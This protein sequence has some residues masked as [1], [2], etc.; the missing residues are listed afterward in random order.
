MQDKQ[1]ERLQTKIADTSEPREIQE[2]LL[3]TGWVRRKLACGDYMFFN[4]EFKRVGIERKSVDD[5][6]TLSLGQRL[7][8]Q[9]EEMLDY[10]DEVILLIE[11]SWKTVSEED[12]LVSF[13][14][15][16]R[17]TWKQVWNFLLE[18]QRS[19]M[20]LQLT[21]DYG[22]TIKRLNELYAIYQ[23]PFSR[24]GLSKRFQDDRVNAFPSGCRGKT[25]ETCLDVFGSL[26][27]VSQ[28]NVEQL[29]SVPGIGQNKAHII[30]HSLSF[31]LIFC[32][33]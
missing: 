7:S 25:A 30:L 13:R 28:A 27:L 14:G 24:S 31:S 15:V 21:I 10:Y 33:I 11:G 26:A 17:S 3:E 8:G 4:H 29:K 9:I 20:M 2:G 19:N 32:C 22:H 16:E 23:Q 1:I 12:H 6:L 18:R 5:L